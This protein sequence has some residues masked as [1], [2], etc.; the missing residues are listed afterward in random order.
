V[1]SVVGVAVV[2]TGSA[3]V[4]PI[5]V[6]GVAVVVT[7]MAMVLASVVVGVAVVTGSAK[8]LATVVIGEAV[9]ETAPMF[10]E[11][12]FTLRT[13]WNKIKIQN[14]YKTTCVSK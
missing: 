10:A 1:G 11:A 2:V 7:G 3:V 5:V 8:V 12:A 13:L 6:V 4:L 14:Y 9:V